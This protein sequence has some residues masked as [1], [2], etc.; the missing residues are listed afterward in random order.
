MFM[1]LLYVFKL[2]IAKQHIHIT[3]RVATLE[4]AMCAMFILFVLIVQRPKSSFLSFVIYLKKCVH[5][6]I[7]VVNLLFL[8]EKFG[9]ELHSLFG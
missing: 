1:L 8:K 7:S 3:L 4:C 2:N 5:N 6:A 9:W